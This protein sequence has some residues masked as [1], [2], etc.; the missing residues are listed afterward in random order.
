[1]IVL[2]QDINFYIYTFF[3]MCDPLMFAIE[4]FSTGIKEKK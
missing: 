1:M 2:L 4:G 3:C